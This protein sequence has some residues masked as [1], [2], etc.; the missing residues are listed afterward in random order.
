MNKSNKPKSN[1]KSDKETKDNNK[2]KPSLKQKI[3]TRRVM[4]K[5]KK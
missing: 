2:E 3:A 1:A 5:S 4:K